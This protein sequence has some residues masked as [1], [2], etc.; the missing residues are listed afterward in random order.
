M[1]RKTL[2][3]LFSVCLVCL[4]VCLSYPSVGRPAC[5]VTVAPC[6]RNPS[7]AVIELSTSI[8]PAVFL[9]TTT[10]A[11]TGGPFVLSPHTAHGFPRR[12]GGDRC[13]GRGHHGVYAAGEHQVLPTHGVRSTACCNQASIDIYLS[14]TM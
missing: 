7:T 10:T 13:G 14:G 11:T 1:H 2:P 9:P 12:M 3:S 6:P 5:H 4:P 8:A